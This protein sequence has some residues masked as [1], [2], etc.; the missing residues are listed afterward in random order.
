MKFSELAIGQQFGLKVGSKME[1]ATKLESR[2]YRFDSG[3]RAGQSWTTSGNATVY[4]VGTELPGKELGSRQGVKIRPSQ[5]GR[6]M[7]FYQRLTPVARQKLDEI[8]E[9]SGRS[10]ADW[11]NDS[12]NEQ[13][14][15]LAE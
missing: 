6:T 13:H 10:Q 5:G 3:Y 11:L 12:I 15:K 1:T 2:R 4:E 8:L 14:A 9:K 7:S